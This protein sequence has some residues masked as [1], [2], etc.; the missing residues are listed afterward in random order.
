M[1]YE[2]TCPFTVQK[3]KGKRQGFD[4][5]KATGKIKLSMLK[6]SY[7]ATS[8]PNKAYGKDGLKLLA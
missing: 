6:H 7:P 2:V 5:S 3:L 1:I 4:K 8:I